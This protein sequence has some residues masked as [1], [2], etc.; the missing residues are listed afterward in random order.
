MKGLPRADDIDD[1][2]D[3]FESA[4][5]YTQGR[6]SI[7]NIHLVTRPDWVYDFFR[8]EHPSVQRL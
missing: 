8:N 1:N 3:T 6:F 5:L 2:I 7:E 4:L